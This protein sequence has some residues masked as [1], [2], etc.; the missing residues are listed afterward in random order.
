MTSD[1]AVPERGTTEEERREWVLNAMGSFALS[2]MQPT[3]M[4]LRQ[5]REFISGEKTTARHAETRRILRPAPY[6][7]LSHR[8]YTLAP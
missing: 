2:G 8:R 3:P 5:A 7:P 1:D 6:P 4:A